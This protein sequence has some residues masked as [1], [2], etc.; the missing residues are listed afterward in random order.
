[1]MTSHIITPVIRQ[2]EAYN[3]RDI[4]SFIVNFSE[5]CVVEDGE[6]KILMKGREAMY[7]SYRAMFENSPH[8]YCHVSSRT[9]VGNY[10]L[11]KERVSGR[12]GNSRDSLVVAIYRVEQ[13]KIV[14]VRFLK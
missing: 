14:H 6:G 8:L 1:M 2:L 10:V 12:N 11:D 7:Q 9:V 3:K 13:E 4:D 5:N